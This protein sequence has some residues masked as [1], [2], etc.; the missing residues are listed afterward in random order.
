LP[1]LDSVVDTIVQSVQRASST[2]PSSLSVPPPTISAENPSPPISPFA[3]DPSGSLSLSLPIVP[4]H[5]PSTCSTYASSSTD[6]SHIISLLH[7]KHASQQ[8]FQS[9]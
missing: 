5:I 6:L 2:D 3:H 8:A 9:E 1:N 7:S 4:T